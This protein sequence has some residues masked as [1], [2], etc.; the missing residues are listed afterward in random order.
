MKARNFFGLLLGL[1][2]FAAWLLLVGLCIT[3]MTGCGSSR[4]TTQS[5]ATSAA[6][7]HVV[8]DRS[9]ESARQTTEH[10]SQTTASETDTERVTTITENTIITDFSPPDSL[11]NQHKVRETSNTKQTNETE[12][13][14]TSQQSQS[15]NGKETAEAAADTTHVD[16][17]A[18]AK[19]TAIVVEEKERER[20]AGDYLWAIA[21][22]AAAMAIWLS[23]R[24]LLAVIKKITTFF[25]KPI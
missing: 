6:S 23:R 12:R 14:G 3:A 4:R 24:K 25:I 1:A 11:G 2:V 18:N 7:E 10:S 22:G 9:S 15:S 16:A 5:T 17:A 20:G 8:V 19:Q 21:I 13:A